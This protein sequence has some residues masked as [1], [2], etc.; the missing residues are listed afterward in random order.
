MPGSR[1]LHS[2]PW[3][4]HGAWTESVWHI[5]GSDEVWDRSVHTFIPDAFAI[6]TVLPRDLS[7]WEDGDNRIAQALRRG[8]EG[9]YRR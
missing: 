4:S 1:T 8:N 9:F 7:G 3:S 6:A 2:L 5:Q